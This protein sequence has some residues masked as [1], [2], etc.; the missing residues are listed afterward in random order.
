[1]PASARIRAWTLRVSVS[2][3]ILPHSDSQIQ[4]SYRTLDLQG[5]R[6]EREW[7]AYG[8]EGVDIGSGLDGGGGPILGGA[9]ENCK[10]C[11]RECQVNSELLND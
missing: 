6:D 9:V 4:F 5:T 8:C 7:T 3:S 2:S 10:S 1:M 11:Q